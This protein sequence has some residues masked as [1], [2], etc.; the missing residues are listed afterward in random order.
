MV[1]HQNI[2]GGKELGYSPWS[3]SADKTP[4][5]AVVGRCSVAG[6]ILRWSLLDA[7]DPSNHGTSL[8]SAAAIL[9]VLCLHRVEWPCEELLDG[10]EA[11]SSQTEPDF[12]RE[13]RRQLRRVAM[14]VATQKWRAG[15]RDAPAWTPWPCW[16]RP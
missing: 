5:S 12:C 6:A 3:P 7:G 1:V 9:A 16:P 13:P 4:D 8:E 11:F 14:T 10:R 2:N 15:P